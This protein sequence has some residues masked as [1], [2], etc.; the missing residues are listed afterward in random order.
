MYRKQ[1]KNESIYSFLFL[2]SGT[3]HADNRW[4]NMADVLPWDQ[5]E[6]QSAVQSLS[7]IDAGR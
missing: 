6:I 1:D 2:F 3:L 4:A 7:N 5:R